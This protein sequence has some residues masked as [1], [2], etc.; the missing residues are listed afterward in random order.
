MGLGHWAFGVEPQL[1]TI[2]FTEWLAVKTS[3]CKDFV[4]F[5]VVRWNCQWTVCSQPITACIT[6]HLNIIHD[7]SHRASHCRWDKTLLETRNTNMYLWQRRS[8]ESYQVPRELDT[9]L[10]TSDKHHDSSSPH[11]RHTADRLES[12]HSLDTTQTTFHHCHVLHVHYMHI[13]QSDL[14]HFNKQK[15]Y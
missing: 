8:C 10:C 3:G 15:I 1:K 6:K 4:T 2:W 12:T 7:T 5:C 9:V 13:H 11:R 14:V